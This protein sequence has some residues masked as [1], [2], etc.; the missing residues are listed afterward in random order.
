MVINIQHTEVC[1]TFAAT[2]QATDQHPSFY[3]FGDTIVGCYT[4]SGSLSQLS[5][6]VSLNIK[7]HFPVKLESQLI[8]NQK[9][10]VASALLLLLPGHVLSAVHQASLAGDNILRLK[11]CQDTLTTVSA[12][13]TASNWTFEHIHSRAHTLMRTHVMCQALLDTGG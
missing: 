3:L 7:A 12:S 8:P 6:L 11:L 5:R 9:T 2:A 13:Y 4:D 10:P 1:V